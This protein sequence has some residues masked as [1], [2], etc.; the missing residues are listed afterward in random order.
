VENQNRDDQRTKELIDEIQNKTRD[1]G[2]EVKRRV[3]EKIIK[4]CQERLDQLPHPDQGLPDSG[5]GGGG[6]SGGGRPEPTP[7]KR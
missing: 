3:L 2:D 5:S 4:A 1:L 7:Q 6:G